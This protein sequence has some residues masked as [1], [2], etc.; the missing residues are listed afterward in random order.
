M[1]MSSTLIYEKDK[2]LRIEKSVNL[3]NKSHFFINKKTAM[4][5]VSSY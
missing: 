4:M 3:A 5:Y 1:K 2:T